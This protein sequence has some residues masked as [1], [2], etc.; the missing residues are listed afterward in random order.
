MGPLD[1]FL[2]VSVAEPHFLSN[3][4]RSLFTIL[5]Y[6]MPLHSK[7]KSSRM[8]INSSHHS[9]QGCT[10][11]PTI[12]DTA[13]NSTFQKGDNKWDAYWG[14][15]NV[16][17]HRTKFSRQGELVV[18]NLQD[19]GPRDRRYISLTVNRLPT[20]RSVQIADGGRRPERKAIHHNPVPR[21][22][23][24]GAM[25][26]YSPMRLHRIVIS[27]AQGHFNLSVVV[28]NAWD[29]TLTPLRLQCVT[30]NSTQRHHKSQNV[31]TKII[32]N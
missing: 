13:Q 4:A 14:T 17:R 8:L 3:P 16:R 11:F 10:N 26:P 22:R 27:E 18:I 23:M 1:G 9:D 12:T 25:P 24:S 2:P 29:Y 28:K 15:A 32:C 20:F 19:G 7:H 31:Q 5:S 21:L 6:S 30:T